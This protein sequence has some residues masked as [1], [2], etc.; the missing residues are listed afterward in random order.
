M[1]Q[2]PW[3]LDHGGLGFW[4]FPH[5]PLLGVRDLRSPYRLPGWSWG[6]HPC[7]QAAWVL[8]WGL[9]VFAL[10]SALPARRPGSCP[11]PGPSWGAI[12]PWRPAVTGPPRGPGTP[13]G[14][15]GWSVG[16]ALR[17]QQRLSDSAVSPSRTV[18]EH[19]G[20]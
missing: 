3:P 13:A 11:L 5:G 14:A 18:V 1:A 17:C 7:R 4:T 8:L 2:L 15:S 20:R 12:T 6:A 16:W 10:C 19:A 9:R